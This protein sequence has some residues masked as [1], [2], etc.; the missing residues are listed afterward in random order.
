M[1]YH[2]VKWGMYMKVPRFQLGIHKYL[3]VHNLYTYILHSH[4][5]GTWVQSE[6]KF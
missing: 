5:Q 3:Y 1:N 2:E 6:S 4:F